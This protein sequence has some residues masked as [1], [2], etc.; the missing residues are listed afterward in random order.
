MIGILAAS[1]TEYMSIICHEAQY[2]TKPEIKERT[3]ELFPYRL[4]M[5]NHND[6]YYQGLACY[7]RANTQE[8]VSKVE[9]SLVRGNHHDIYYLQ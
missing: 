9:H 3:E 5:N 6:I 1:M 4:G 8:T 7:E 2:L